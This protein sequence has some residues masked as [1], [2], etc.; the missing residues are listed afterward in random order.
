[1]NLPENWSLVRNSEGYTE[2][3]TGEGRPFSV[4]FPTIP[5][6]IHQPMVKAVGFKGKALNILDVT[7]GWG[8]DAFLLSSLGCH[9]TAIEKHDLVFSLLKEGFSR[10]E[11]L[12]KGSLQLVHNDSINYLNT[13]SKTSEVIY[14]DPFFGK[15]KKSLSSKS[16]RIL[17]TLAREDCEFK[18]LF[19]KCLQKAGKRLVVKRHRL[20]PSLKGPL[21]CSFRGRSVCYD[22]FSPL[23]G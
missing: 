10:I 21:L 7:A 19:Q 11:R 3:H 18:E 15:E 22:V 1:M 23:N 12:K 14:M 17:Q 4:K 16:L 6:L 2:L 5:P 13:T 20:Q 8:Q 9:V